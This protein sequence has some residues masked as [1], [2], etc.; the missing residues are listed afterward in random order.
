MKLKELKELINSNK[1]TDKQLRIFACWCARRHWD[2]LD[3]VHVACIKAA[4]EYI[5]NKITLEQMTEIKEYAAHCNDINK[6]KSDA[7]V[8][9]RA[10]CTIDAKQAAYRSALA[11]IK[12]SNNKTAINEVIHYLINNI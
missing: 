6:P 9:A 8:A 10:C 3:C 5:N 7:N 2:S 12:H 1:Y 4:E 11:S